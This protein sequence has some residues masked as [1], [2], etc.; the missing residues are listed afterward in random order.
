[1]RLFIKILAVAVCFSGF[2]SSS[3][4]QTHSQQI[5]L[6]DSKPGLLI[7]PTRVVLEG[8]NR[9]AAITIA[10]NGNKE[11]NYKIE[12]VNKR[13]KEDGSIVDADTTE[14]GELF[15]TD[16][17]RIS[18]RRVK[19]P[20]GGYQN[21]RILVRKPA[22]LPDGEYRSHLRFMVVQDDEDET[23]EQQKT[24]ETGSGNDGSL[25]ISIKANF[26]V[27]IPVIVRNGNLVE[28]ASMGALSL[29]NKEGNKVVSF[30]IEREGARSL[31][32]DI[33]V[34]YT[35]SAGKK[36]ILNTLGGIAVY[37][38]NA[39]RTM[40]VAIDVNQDVK[41]DKGRIDVE[42]RNK[43]ADGGKLIAS[44]SIQL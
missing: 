44:S 1:M 15:A 13:M 30:T 9:A 11:G 5:T 22:N 7:T 26:G 36:F 32:G 23:E 33:I 14:A 37:T 43:E 42:Y 19:I 6:P 4:A 39:K 20:A 27:T 16:I 2:V 3:I 41:I 29:G 8:K 38:P 21:V 40:D 17:L 25:S 10:N 12:I 34:T 31:Y 28:K 35:N 18:P 24:D